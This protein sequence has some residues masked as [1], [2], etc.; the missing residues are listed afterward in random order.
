MEI[1]WVGM[2]ELDEAEQAGVERRF[3][4]LADGHNDLIDLRVTGRKSGHHVHGEQEVRITCQ[5]RGT[6]IVAHRTRPDLALA[7]NEAVD[8]FEREV[9]KLRERRRDR[10]RV[11]SSE[12]G[13]TPVPEEM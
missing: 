7:L 1:H 8:V 5:A 11:R 2:T 6:E 9:H 12:P 10:R 3:T 4:K 13:G